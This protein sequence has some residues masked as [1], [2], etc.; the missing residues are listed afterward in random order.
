MVFD[1]RILV[2]LGDFWQCLNTL[3]SLTRV[4]GFPLLRPLSNVLT[5]LVVK[6]GVAVLFSLMLPR[7]LPYGEQSPSQKHLTQ[8]VLTKFEKPWSKGQASLHQSEG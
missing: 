6:A 2:Y 8:K 1:T 7:L 3:L 5:L 4:G